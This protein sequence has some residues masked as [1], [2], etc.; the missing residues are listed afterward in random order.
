MAETLYM[1]TSSK[2]GWTTIY[3]S[4]A[5]DKRLSLKG[6][7]LFLLMQSLPEDWKYTVA[8]LAAK[9]YLIVRKPYL[10]ASKI[11]QERV[12]KHDKIEVLFEHNAVGLFGENG[13]EGCIWYSVWVN[14]M[15]SAMMWPLTV[16]SWL[17]AIS[18]TLI[19][20]NLM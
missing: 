16:S 20:S 6:R 18:P 9:V 1:R 8:G 17:S 7:G 2:R 15:R 3:R 12:M 5:Q 13:V 11:M 14:L 4:V 19:F 10:R